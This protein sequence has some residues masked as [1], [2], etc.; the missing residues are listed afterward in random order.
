MRS[1]SSV[2]DE[3]NTNGPKVGIFWLVAERLI[4]DSTPLDL[5]EDYANCKTHARSH[6]EFWQDLTR[7][8]AIV[9][10]DYEEHPRGRIVYNTA[11]KRFKRMKGE[12]GYSSRRSWE[13]ALK[14]SPVVSAKRKCVFPRRT[15][16]PQRGH[17]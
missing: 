6:L 11:T 9:E 3:E 17:F 8:G 7:A 1:S 16:H 14:R 13:Y 15:Q 12:A 10:D 2:R 5:A 4:A